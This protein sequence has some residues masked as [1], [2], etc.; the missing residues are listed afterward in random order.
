MTRKP[1]DWMSPKSEL[2]G[3]NQKS[4]KGLLKTPFIAMKTF[5][6]SRQKTTHKKWANP[7]KCECSLKARQHHHRVPEQKSV[8]YA[9]YKH[10]NKAPTI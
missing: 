6:I 10:V 2:L 9:V 3:C 4:N 7:F 8:P 1:C 5:T